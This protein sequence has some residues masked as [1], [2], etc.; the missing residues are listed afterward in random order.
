MRIAILTL[1]LHTN[2]GGILQ[3]YALQTVL[4]RMG[5]TVELIQ[6]NP[7]L[8]EW[9][10]KVPFSFIKRHIKQLYTSNSKAP[11]KGIAYTRQNTDRF[12]DKYIHRRL[13]SSI[14]DIRPSDYDCIVVGSDQ[15]W[16][17]IYYAPRYR[18]V[19]YSIDPKDAFLRF[20]SG[21]DIKRIVYAASFGVDDWEYSLN[22]T[23]SCARLLQKF[24][25]VSLR[26]KS[27]VENCTNYLGC[28]AEHVL[29]PTMLLEKDDYLELIRV[30]GISHDLSADNKMFCYILDRNNNKNRIINDISK[31]TGL[32]PIYMTGDIVDTIV[33]P[34]VEQWIAAINNSSVVVTDS[35]HAC[36]FSIIFKKPF[37]A[38]GNKGRGL[39]RFNS[40]LDTF[41]LK[42]R[43]I[44]EDSSSYPSLDNGMPENIDSALNHWRKKSLRFLSNAIK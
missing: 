36:V 19:M 25:S 28:K 39:S 22:E 2:Y 8:Q 23:T 15:I 27:G 37:I 41:N 33:Q 10:W 14:S 38:I 29:D 30:A 18:S 21:W 6:K 42:D 12:I 5:H 3:A 13:I 7:S 1:P 44:D 31:N 24:D 40:L 20:A 17:R 34:P 4:E 9:N 16:R 26:E 11:Q 32:S 43:L 35:F